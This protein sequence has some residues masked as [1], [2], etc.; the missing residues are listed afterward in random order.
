MPVAADDRSLLHDLLGPAAAALVSSIA[1]DE[2]LEAGPGRL[3]EL[4]L[5]RT[6]RRRL[7]ASA[8]VARRYQP[9]CPP[10]LSVTSPRAVLPYLTSL[11]RSP[12]EVLGVLAL[13]ARQAALGAV[14][15]VAEGSVSHVTA[16]PREVFSPA[17]ERRASAIVLA[18]NHPSGNAEPSLEDLE[19]TRAMCEAG[20]VLGIQVLD[21]LVVARRAYV[22]LRERGL[23]DARDQNVGAR[24]AS[25]SSDISPNK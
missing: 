6:A 19:F 21:H 13:D 8:E 15:R 10:P 17:L 25:S 23:L 2:L 9:A 14:V 1:L 24:L 20:A 16:E 5:R 11:R 3:A 7:L 18:H 12:T 4:G 22:S